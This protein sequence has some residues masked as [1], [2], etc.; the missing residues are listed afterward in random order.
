[1]VTANTYFGAWAIKEAL[2]RGADIVICPR[3]TDAAVVIG[4]AAW[5]FDW[6]RSDYDALAGA[7]T[8]GHIIECGAQ[9]TGGNYSLLRSP[10]FLNMG[11]AEIERDGSL[12]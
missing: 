11:I 6:Q 7:L 2:D 10:G 3:V 5:K 9:C 1:M 8:A 4:P 12:P